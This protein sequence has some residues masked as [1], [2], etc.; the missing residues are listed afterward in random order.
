MKKIVT[1]LALASPALIFAQKDGLEEFFDTLGG[2][3]STVSA[4][5]FAAAVIFFFWNLMK[6]I[7]SDSKQEATQG[8][9]WGVIILFVMTSVY[10]LV[11]ILSETIE[12]DESASINVPTLPT[13]SSSE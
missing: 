3:L 12:L 5:L 4:L 8:M 10:G 13:S 11:N 1:I 7:M 6:Y 9:I 2:L